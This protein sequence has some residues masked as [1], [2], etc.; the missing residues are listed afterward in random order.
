MYQP[1]FWQDALIAVQTG[2]PH[3]SQQREDCE[4]RLMAKGLLSTERIDKNNMLIS[5]IA[6]KESIPWQGQQV[7]LDEHAILGVLNNLQD[8]VR[9]IDELFSPPGE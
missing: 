7:V 3:K 1:L 9:R 2:K 8:T 4:K 5:K 6:A